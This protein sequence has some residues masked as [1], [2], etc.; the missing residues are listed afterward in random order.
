MIVVDDVESRREADVVSSTRVKRTG[1]LGGWLLV[2]I[3]VLAVASPAAFAA[4]TTCSA[5]IVDP[6]GTGCVN[7]LNVRVA[8][9]AS[10]DAALVTEVEFS[11]DGLDWYAMDYT[12]RAQ[13]W[14]LPGES[15]AKTLYVRF[16]AADGSVSPVT[17]TG[18][19][20]DTEGPRTAALRR[21]R[22]AA[23][24]R[25]SFVFDLDDNVSPS[26]DARLVI[27][28]ANGSR[29]IQLGSLATGR[30]SVRLRVTL[31]RGRYTWSVLAIDAARWT[32]SQ[33][34]SQTLVVD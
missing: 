4:W 28:G 23:G 14:V 21:V 26:V 9:Q 17:T 15:G 30:H 33:K 18:I 25:G 11:D 29:N 10:N 12:G 24:A 8:N 5:R 6:Y 16:V 3:L 22:V 31:P 19:T 2:A 27:R 13:D 7:L 32:Q 34:V 20:V 1:I